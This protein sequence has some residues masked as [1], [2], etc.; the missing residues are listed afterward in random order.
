MQLEMGL[1]PGQCHILLLDRTFG[2]GRRFDASRISRSRAQN[3]LRADRVVAANC[4]TANRSRSPT[5]P[6]GGKRRPLRDLLRAA[7]VAELF[8]DLTD[9]SFHTVTDPWLFSFAV[10]GHV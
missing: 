2:L 5:L 3:N 8:K 10:T 7:F 9:E 1:S 6:K 4:W